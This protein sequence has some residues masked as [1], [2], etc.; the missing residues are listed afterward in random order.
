MNE[1]RFETRP[2]NTLAVVSLLAGIA[3]YFGVVCIGAVVAIVCGHKAR[4]QIRQTGEAGDGLAVAGLI[5]GYLHIALSAIFLVVW[6]VA[7]GG[8]LMLSSLGNH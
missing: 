8:I 5:L 3:S 1:E 2:N 6:L 7:F 4:S